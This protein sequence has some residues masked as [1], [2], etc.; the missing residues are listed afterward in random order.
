MGRESYCDVERVQLN[1]LMNGW[2]RLLFLFTNN[3][4]N[5]KKTVEKS[6]YLM[7]LNYREFLGELSNLS[8]GLIIR[9][10]Y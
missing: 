6:E 9:R 1:G 8:D 4:N 3:N 10:N 2:R 5:S 7:S